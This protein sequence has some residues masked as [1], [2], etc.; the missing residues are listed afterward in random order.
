MYVEG[1]RESIFCYVAHDV[2]SMCTGDRAAKII[3]CRT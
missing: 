2:G 3:C 1:Y